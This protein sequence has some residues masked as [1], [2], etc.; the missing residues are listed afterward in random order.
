MIKSVDWN[1]RALKII[2][3]T[4]IPVELSYP[5]LSTVEEVFHA[6]KTLMVRG[7]PAIGV[8]AGFGLYLGLKNYAHL[9]NEQFLN[10]A[11]ETANYLASSRPTAVNLRWALDT[12]LHRLANFNDPLRDKLDYLLAQA[13][14]I[15]QDDEKRCLAIA[16][17]GNAIVPDGARILTHCNAGA[18]ATAGIGTALGVIY[19]AHVSGKRIHVYVDETRPLLQGARLTVWELDNAGVNYTLITDSMAAHAMRLNKIDMV[20]VGADRIALNGD[21]ANK[22][23]TYGLAVNCHFHKIPFYVAAPVSTFDF[24]IENGLEIPI[25]ERA[26][27]EIYNI[28]DKLQIS[29]PRANAWNPAF[30]VTPNELITGIITEK[31]ILKPPFEKSIKEIIL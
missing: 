27:S 6:I 15:K 26:G 21:T 3:Q 19:Q 11:A 20:I 28:W 9:N 16:E 2:D 22:I 17:A 25:E 30:D 29:L 10:K 14:E 5:E 1:G 7:A 12:I 13:L 18:L 31:G 23:G 8:A 24:K 4:K